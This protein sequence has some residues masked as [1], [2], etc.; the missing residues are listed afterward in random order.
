MPYSP[1]LVRPFR[2]ELTMLGIQE[3][4]TPKHVD[5]IM[6]KSGTTMI[7]VNSVCGCAA[8]TA[9]P[10]VA[11]ALEHNKKPD[12]IATVFAGQDL[13]ATARFRNYIADIPPSSPSIAFFKDQELVAF[14]P[15]HRIEGRDANG[16]ANDL[17]A[18]FDEFC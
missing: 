10:G 5:E 8:G 3:L 11:R 16:L 9:R 1:L 14:I 4:P 6:D 13:E 2:E 12:R 15:K 18:V 17:V 7:V